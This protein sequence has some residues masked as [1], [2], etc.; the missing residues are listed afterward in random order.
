HEQTFIVE[1]DGQRPISEGQ[2]VYVEIP[3]RDVH[4]F[5]AKS[6]ETIHQRRLGDDAE[7]ALEE[8]MKPAE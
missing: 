7:T 6:G 4:L 1:T 2:H 3:D 8:Q 5:D